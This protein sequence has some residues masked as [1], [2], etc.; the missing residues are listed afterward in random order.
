M[1]PITSPIRVQNKFSLF[2]IVIFSISPFLLFPMNLSLKDHLV[3]D[4]KSLSQLYL[5]SYGVA[6]ILV[7]FSHS[8]WVDSISRFDELPDCSKNMVDVYIFPSKLLLAN[9][10]DPDDL[11]LSRLKPS[12]NTFTPNFRFHFVGENVS[13]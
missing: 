10:F 9:G 12:R 3:A 1:A 4:F 6:S 7:V 11:C 8:R 13:P 2:W 5:R